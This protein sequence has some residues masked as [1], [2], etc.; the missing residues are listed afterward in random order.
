MAK[1][2]VKNLE[3]LNTWLPE[4]ASVLSP[5]TPAKPQP[6]G[7]TRFGRKG[8]LVVGPEAGLWYDHE[9]GVGGRDA[10][11]LIKHLGDRDPNKWVK[12]FLSDHDGDGLL[13]GEPTEDPRDALE[14][15]CA[16]VEFF[17][18]QAT[19][20]KGTPAG[21]YLRS[22]GI[23]GPY[24]ENLSYVPEARL[25]EGA[26]MATVAEADGTAVAVQLTYL[27]ANGK[28]SKVAPTRRLYRKTTDWSFTGAFTLS[29]PTAPKRTVLT[30]GVEDALSLWKAAA[31]TTVI[32][33]LGVQNFG[34]APIDPKADVIIFRDGDEPESS[35]D[36]AVTRGVDRL[37]LAGAAVRVT[38][39]ALGS[40]AN[41][42]FL[43]E[44]PTE[45][46]R[47]IEAA[48]VAELST[49]GWFEKCARMPRLDFEQNR[50][51]IA[52]NLDIRVPFLDEEVALRRSDQEVTVADEESAMGLS[53]IEPWDEPVELGSILDEIS[54]TIAQY[55]H[56]SPVGIDTCTL[57]AALTHVTDMVHVL[58]RLAAQSPGPGCG[59]TVLMEVISNLSPKAL[60]AASITAASVFRVIE[61]VRP[62]LLIDEADQL[63]RSDNKELLGILNSGHRRSSAYV[64]RV[65][66]VSPGQHE[67][68]RFSTWGPMMTAGIGTLP[69]TLEDRS[70]VIRLQR[71]L[72]SE[73]RRHLRD[74]HCPVLLVC[75]RKLTRWGS[76]LA[77]LPDVDLPPQFSNRIGDNWR[78][79]FAIA[80]LAGGEWPER[81]MLAAKG[82]LS[83]SDG[84]AIAILLQDIQ[85]VFGEQDR[86]T[87]QEIVD[88]LTGLDEAP[89]GE[90]NRG[91]AITTNWLAKQLKGVINGTSQSIRSGSRT[92]KGYHRHQFKE[93]WRRYGVSSDNLSDAVDP[94]GTGGTTAHPLETKPSEDLKNGT[95]DAAQRHT[96][97]EQ[98]PVLRCADPGVTDKAGANPPESGACAG[99]TD[100]PDDTAGPRDTSAGVAEQEVW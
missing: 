92:A 10:L 83:N 34:K 36:K 53:D 42:T 79:L 80:Q 55:V 88:K 67:T 15:S 91:R 90:V 16:A 71:A 43:S 27:S 48:P 64:L 82:A 46:L 61:A 59:K 44:G 33:C 20:L 8:S 62:T 100:V 39:T 41:D 74:G 66:E 58:P 26:L 4:I 72:P 96:L 54:A 84:G 65:V 28:K 78:P 47:L 60:M 18:A 19:G 3:R 49:E 35:A 98:D 45:L 86:M 50:K 24:P 52:S 69:P 40:D 56:L 25:G 29:S 31:G 75:A 76:E 95:P 11:S 12:K 30:E 57:W 14:A 87:S 21:T 99:V 7:S 68:I 73:V 51:S 2:S 63:F 81:V 5:D 85:E 70:I 94:G 23:K 93:A 9:A 13:S 89:Y 38:E 32:A 6:N 17:L 97:T 22:R 1:L 77:E 37:I